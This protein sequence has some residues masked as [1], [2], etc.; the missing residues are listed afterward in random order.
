[1]IR[2]L[3]LLLCFS[4]QVPM[5]LADSTFKH[6]GNFIIVSHMCSEPVKVV[7]MVDDTLGSYDV[8]PY[9]NYEVSN[10]KA[11]LTAFN[12]K[13]IFITPLDNALLTVARIKCP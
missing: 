10:L 6:T 4:V 8:N 5:V 12:E 11:F 9:D 2:I 7:Y 1:M 13:Q 3:T